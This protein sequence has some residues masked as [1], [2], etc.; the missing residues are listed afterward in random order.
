MDNKFETISD[1]DA[2]TDAIN[3]DV[4]TDFGDDLS[5][6]D[7]M[8]LNGEADINSEQRKVLSKGGFTR[9]LAGAMAGVAGVY[10]MQG[11]LPSEYD[12]Y[13]G[14]GRPEHQAFVDDA[15]AERFNSLPTS[16]NDIFNIPST[17]PF[18]SEGQDRMID[19]GAGAGNESL[20]EQIEES[21]FGDH[22]DPPD[23][24]GDLNADIDMPNFDA[25]PDMDFDMSM[26]F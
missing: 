13:A 14:D 8:D 19:E 15:T 25:V 6:D 1:M 17:S 23:S 16:E 20:F 11:E 24:F 26:D 5:S 12:V 7:G 9:G 2:G 3:N 22:I 4:N 10:G 18:T 21:E